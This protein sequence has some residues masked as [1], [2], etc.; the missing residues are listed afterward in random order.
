MW[1]EASTR[2]STLRATLGLYLVFQLMGCIVASLT[3]MERER[4]QKKA[5]ER[6]VFTGLS[7]WRLL[8]NYCWALWLKHSPF[9][10]ALV[11]SWFETLGGNGDHVRKKLY[12]MRLKYY[13]HRSV[14]CTLKSVV[15]FTERV[16]LICEPGLAYVS[17]LNTAH[18]GVIE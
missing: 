16:S 6:A 7:E 18:S 4:E 10:P 5:R 14:L 9:G 11:N 2:F 1:L 15:M 17:C 13:V 3:E 12:L 8:P